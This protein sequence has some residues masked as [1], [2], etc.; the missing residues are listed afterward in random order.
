MNQ[1]NT[2]YKGILKVTA[3][4]VIAGIAMNLVGVIDLI[5]VTGLGEP[6]VG[7]TG[8][9]Q[10]LYA[11]LF[12]VGMGFTSGMQ[13]IIGR[14]NGSHDYQKIGGLFFQGFYFVLAF[15]LL[16]FVFIQTTIPS[17]LDTLFDSKNVV[18]YATI[19]SLIHI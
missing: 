5:L 7:G 14:R 11:L 15:A 12:V 19:L 10:L 17:L 8:N 2:T 13:I 4:L 1:L 3:P 16:L 6:Q 18:N 9:G